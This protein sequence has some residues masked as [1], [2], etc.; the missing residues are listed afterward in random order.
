MSKKW[1]SHLALLEIRHHQGVDINY[2]FSFV[3]D[4]VHIG[5]WIRRQ[6]HEYKVCKLSHEKIARLEAIGF[7]WIIDHNF[8]YDDKY[9]ERVWE[10]HFAILHSIY[11]AGK[12]VNVP[13]NLFKKGL[14]IGEW[15]ARQ[16]VGFKMKRLSSEKIFRLESIGF[17]W[18]I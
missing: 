10:D 17:K 9:E 12:N 11:C 3:I 2:E 1:E 13:P 6:R 8:R 18:E 4:G 16:R 7:R 14:K 15:V 5:K